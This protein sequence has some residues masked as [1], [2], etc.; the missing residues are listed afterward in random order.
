[1]RRIRIVSVGL[2]CTHHVFTILLCNLH[3]KL[4]SDVTVPTYQKA[5]NCTQIHSIHAI[6]VLHER[7]TM[8]FQ[9]WY[10]QTQSLQNQGERSNNMAAICIGRTASSALLIDMVSKLLV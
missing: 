8:D 10:T 3:H 7:A 9:V 5:S 4:F 1:M 2:Q 6:A